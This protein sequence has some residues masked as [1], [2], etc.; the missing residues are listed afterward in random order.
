LAQGKSGASWAF[1]IACFP[2][3]PHS[4]KF[5]P[6]IHFNDTPHRRKNKCQMERGH[7]SPE[8]PKNPAKELRNDIQIVHIKNI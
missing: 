5:S 7:K 1:S 2:D 6:P 4:I 8:I 3:N